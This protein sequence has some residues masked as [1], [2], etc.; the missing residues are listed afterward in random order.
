[1][2]AN[3]N[4][5]RL[6]GN[7]PRSLAAAPSY[8]TGW[9]G[10]PKGSDTPDPGRGLGAA[11]H[12]SADESSGSVVSLLGGILKLRW[13]VNAIWILELHPRTPVAC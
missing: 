4:Q 13:R 5:L 8:A 10:P 1:M 2:R 9:R 12:D 7:S 6:T 3:M 11:A